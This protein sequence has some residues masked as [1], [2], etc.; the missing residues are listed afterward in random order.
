MKK[1]QQQS[2]QGLLANQ[3]LAIAIEK[4]SQDRRLGYKN[5]NLARLALARKHAWDAYTHTP[6]KHISWYDDHVGQLKKNIKNQASVVISNDWKPLGSLLYM[7][8]TPDSVIRYILETWVSDVG[9]SEP[10][11]WH[12][13]TSGKESVKRIDYFLLNI[14]AH[15]KMGGV[16]TKYKAILNCIHDMLTFAKEQR[17][18]TQSRFTNINHR[19]ET[20]D[21]KHMRKQQVY[22]TV[23][24]NLEDGRKFYKDKLMHA[25]DTVA[26]DLPFTSSFNAQRKRTYVWDAFR[27]ALVR[28]LGAIIKKH[29]YDPRH[30]AKYT[31][32][33]KKS[34]PTKYKG[35]QTL[36]KQK[37]LTLNPRNPK[38]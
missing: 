9:I 2:L 6:N 13:Q 4:L 34:M 28:E 29:H 20:L 8:R 19:N 5:K 23:I 15:L 27:E 25:L 17:T 1:V 38:T 12:D 26:K 14:L 24:K 30:P 11:L 35:K 33:T 31:F 18:S 10:F 16:G 32:K 36:H 3:A 7:L 22:A 21:V 37:T